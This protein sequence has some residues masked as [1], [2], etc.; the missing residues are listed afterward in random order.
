MWIF[1]LLFVPMLNVA[2]WSQ[3]TQPSVSAAQKS[4]QFDG[5]WW[6]KSSSDGLGVFSD[7]LA[8]LDAALRPGGSAGLLPSTHRAR[9]RWM[10]HPD[11]RG[12]GREPKTAGGRR[13]GGSR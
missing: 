10:G 12:F 1:V 7:G 5:K 2:G 3:P 6:S 13:V 11:L 9:L 4:Q 8:A